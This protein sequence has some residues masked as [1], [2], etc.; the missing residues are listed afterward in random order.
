M[1]RR[2]VS[3]IIFAILFGFSAWCLFG[4]FENK[5]SCVQPPFDFKFS[6]SPPPALG[7]TATLDFTIVSKDR[8]FA[9]KPALVR[10]VIENEDFTWVN[11]NSVLENWDLVENTN[12]MENW[13]SWINGS[14]KGASIILSKVGEPTKI[15][16]TIRAIKTGKWSVEALMVGPFWG[17][18]RLALTISVFENS[19]QVREG[20]AWM[21][22]N[23]AS[24][25][26]VKDNV[27]IS[28]LENFLR[29]NLEV[30]RG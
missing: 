28:S 9:G 7:Q 21:E 27:L 4:N 15:T 10:I 19:A 6:V 1:G 30:V 20:Y 12:W 8:G 18:G 26:V 24:I 16:G 2:T 23:L 22:E 29:E 3:L 13:P 11:D 5:E 14:T 17:W 25:F